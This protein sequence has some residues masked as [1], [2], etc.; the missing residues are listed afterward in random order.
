MIKFMLILSKA[1]SAVIKKFPKASD[2]HISGIP[3]AIGNT[4]KKPA[5]NW[6]P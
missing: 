4:I 2:T 5:K 6:Q 3:K 1:A